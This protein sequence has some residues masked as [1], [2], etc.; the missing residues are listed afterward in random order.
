M[1]IYCSLK[2]ATGL[3]RLI[4][5]IRSLN[6]TLFL[7][8][9][10]KVT[11]LH[12]LFIFH[13]S[14]YVAVL[15][16]RFLSRVTLLLRDRSAVMRKSAVEVRSSYWFAWVSY[17]LFNR[18]YLLQLVAYVMRSCSQLKWVHR[19]VGT[20]LYSLTTVSSTLQ[21]PQQLV[22]NVMNEWV[23]VSGYVSGST[24]VSC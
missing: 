2:K 9:R 11:T 5:R 22:A 18:H 19:L 1:L 23:S 4:Q 6:L 15:A 7:L 14:V 3:R 21:C 8:Y 20:C 24:T 13:C 12:F 10:S 17:M 16:P